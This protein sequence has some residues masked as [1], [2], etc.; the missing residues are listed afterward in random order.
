MVINTEA[1]SRVGIQTVT[2][3][4]LLTGGWGEL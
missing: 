2:L 1:E 3:I 4:F